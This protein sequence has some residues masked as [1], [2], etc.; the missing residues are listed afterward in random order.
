MKIY[1]IKCPAC[2]GD[3][4]VK[5]GLNKIFCQYCGAAIALDDEIERKEITY[6]EIDETE[7]QKSNNALELEKL[8]AEEARNH[9]K[10]ML[11][12]AAVCGVLFIALFIFIVVMGW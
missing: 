11:K 4:E 5:D 6:R 3:L 10:L 1:E 8:R 2:G 12:I 7:I 9:Q